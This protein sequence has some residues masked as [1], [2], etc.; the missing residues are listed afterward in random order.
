MAII[1]Q[2]YIYDEIKEIIKFRECL[3][4][5]ISESFVFPSIEKCK[6]KIILPSLLYGC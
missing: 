4:P 3:L 6:K 5:L 2:N 1:Y